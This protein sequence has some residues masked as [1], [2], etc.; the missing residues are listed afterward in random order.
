MA[1]GNIDTGWADGMSKSEQAALA[2]EAPLGR[3]G[4]A[5]EVAKAILFL[6]SPLSSFVTGQTLVIDGGTVIH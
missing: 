2:R 5:D 3:W 6:A 1:P 4:E